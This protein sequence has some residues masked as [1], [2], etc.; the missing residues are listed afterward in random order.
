MKKRDRKLL[1]LSVPFF[2][3]ILMLLMGY[4]G[5]MWIFIQNF[6]IPLI[7]TGYH[8]NWYYNWGLNITKALGQQDNS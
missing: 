4:A 1:I 6:N 3:L 7:G 5:I 8:D 2:F